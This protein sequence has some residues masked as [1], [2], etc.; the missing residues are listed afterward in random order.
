M[1]PPPLLIGAG[2]VF[3][4]WQTGLPFA[5]LAMAVVLESPHWMRARWE[6]SKDDFTRIRSFC[7]LL[8]LAA[9]VLAFSNNQGPS[10]F[11]SLF[12]DPNFFAQR[13]AGA[14]SARTVASL[15]RWLP[16]VFFLLVAAQVFHAGQGIP[17]E[18]FSLV[19][20]RRSKKAPFAGPLGSSGRSID[21]RYPYFV[22]CLLAASV[23][24]S[25]DT[26]FFWGLSALVTWALWP[27]RSPRFG[28]ILWVASLAAAM[29]LGYAG[30]RGLSR[31][32]GW[33]ANYNP[34]WF[35][36]S[37]RGGAD[38]L[39]SK[40]G[41]GHIGRLKGSGKIVVRLS[42]TPGEAAPPLLREASYRAYRK[43]IWYSESSTND[44]ILVQAETNRTTWVLLPSK[45]NSAVV[46]IASYLPGGR[47]LLPLPP[48]S[49]RLD[50]LF[51]FTPP[52]R[53]DLGAVLAEGPGLVVF[54]AR[55]GPGF[56]FDS[57]PNTNLDLAV[58]P[59]EAPALD[60]IINEIGPMGADE[61][62][63]LETIRRFFQNKYHYRI[64][65]GPD[66]MARTNDTPLSVFL[67]RR[68]GGH[69]EYFATA[70]VLLLR[71]LH[72]PARYAVGYAVH[73]G[74]GA[75]YVVRERDAHAWCLVWKENTRTWEDFDTTPYSWV[76]TEAKRASPFEVLSDAWSRFAFE[77]AKLRWGQT[78]L[79]QYLLWAL[80]PV[81]VLLLY[82]IIFRRRRRLSQH[83]DPGAAIVWPGLDSEYYEVERKLA[84]RGL[85]RQ[86][87]E[88]QSQ[89]LLRIA[90][91]PA[92]AQ[93]RGALAEL[94]RLHYRY[95]FDPQGLNASDR[96]TLQ[97]EARTC[98]AR[99]ERQTD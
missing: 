79:R 76:A 43:Q 35:G 84:A 83:A 86:P 28:I 44:F 63:R 56:T 65:E 61:E 12:H 94:L 49:G 73:E 69:C 2:L 15:L 7:A 10:D 1:K 71:E 70:T 16:M 54:D 40:T 97:R 42:T 95:R 20:R 21:L 55:Y 72:I 18:S 57:P 80:A 47:G 11:L 33:L 77:L 31:V 93:V 74:S 32:Q 52:Q 22:L 13:N 78:R 29:A 25:E 85:M 89:W 81:L 66:R 92:A 8:C 17:A 59:K 24:A 67:L 3:W 6:F 91:D 26:T 39:R 23:H 38:P 87:N 60:Q 4:G 90:V 27:Q 98:L 88:P 5:G 68:R 62:Q 46:D 9:L 96:D 48:G 82:Q 30:Q 37:V 14:A 41:I 64:W 58:D 51:V 50:N 36:H 99:M 19:V 75:N 34:R 53:N 45:T